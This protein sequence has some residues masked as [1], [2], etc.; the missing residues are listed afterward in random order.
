MVVIFKESAS[1][2]LTSR[3]LLSDFAQ[4]LD[5]KVP[6]CYRLLFM[7]SSL[8][9]KSL[10]SSFWWMILVNEPM[11]LEGRWILGERVWKEPNKILNKNHPVCYSN[12]SDHLSKFMYGMFKY[13][14]SAYMGFIFYIVFA[15]I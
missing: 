10:V 4:V 11:N 13:M 3:L 8:D 1:H 5:G 14:I 2:S 9:D 7:R 15:Y 6:F 12:C